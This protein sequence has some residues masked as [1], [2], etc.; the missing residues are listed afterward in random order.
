MGLA[1]LEERLRAAARNALEGR[2]QQL[3]GTR[4]RLERQNPRSALLDRLRALQSLR[5]ALERAGRRG[6]GLEERRLR[7]ADLRGRLGTAARAALQGRQEALMVG[8]ASL[9]AFSP[10]RVFER[11][12]SM[13]RNARTGRLVQ[14]PEQVVSGDAL[15]IVLGLRVVSEKLVE[16]S[17]RAVVQPTPIDA[18]H[19]GV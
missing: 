9:E 15:E 5:A 18:P 10:Q 19:P 8:R 16:E 14:S 3:R 4:D 11:G 7:L 6:V 13:T 1:D 2:R 12:Y 17:I